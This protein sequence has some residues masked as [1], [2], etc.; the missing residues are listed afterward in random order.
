M[1]KRINN[2]SI[3]S[4]FNKLAGTG[5]Y[6]SFD[7]FDDF[8]VVDKVNLGWWHCNCRWCRGKKHFR[9]RKSH[10]RKGKTWVSW[11]R[12]R[13]SIILWNDAGYRVLVPEQ[14]KGKLKRSSKVVV[15]S[16]TG[17]CFIKQPS[18]RAKKRRKRISFQVPARPAPS[19]INSATRPLLDSFSE[20]EQK[21]TQ[22]ARELGINSE[23]SISNGFVKL[24]K[25]NIFVN[26]SG[27]VSQDGKPRCVVVSGRAFG[28][29][30]EDRVLSKVLTILYRPELVNTL[31]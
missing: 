21:I 16:R 7:I 23:I 15:S 6:H 30:Y 4:Y 26:Y 22:L 24:R 11:K 5:S 12:A 31:G 28:L 18:R 8:T 25:K 19:A 27:N 10:C 29:P 17:R 9:D 3:K 13:N 14:R 1:Q 2:S 20:R